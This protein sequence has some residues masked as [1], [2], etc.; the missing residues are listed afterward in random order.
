MD[1]PGVGTA[2]APE[3]AKYAHIQV[4]DGGHYYVPWN[5]L[6]GALEGETDMEVGEEVTITIKAVEMTDK[7]FFD[8][9]E[10]EGH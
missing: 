5:S 7:E 9:P 4:H 10:F 6:G 3:K 8:L 2:P 1:R